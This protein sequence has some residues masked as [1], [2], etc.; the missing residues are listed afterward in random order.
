M[1]EPYFLATQKERLLMS[2]QH[3]TDDTNNW[4]ILADR[5]VWSDEQ[6]LSLIPKEISDEEI[7]KY[8]YTFHSD[9][10]S[11]EEIKQLRTERAQDQ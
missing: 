6:A 9:N 2:Y 3:H 1:L 10:I 11:V 4:R 8:L 5:F 7:Q